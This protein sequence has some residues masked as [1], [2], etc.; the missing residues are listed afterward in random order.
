MNKK[1][2]VLATALALLLTAG[3]KSPA[4]IPTNPT[5]YS[6]PSVNTGTWTALQTAATEITGT[7]FT[8]NTV[9]QGN[10]CYAVTAIVNNQSPIL[11]S[12]PSNTFLANIAA[13]QTSEPLVW[14]AG[15]GGITPTGYIMYRIAAIQTSL[16]TPL[17][18]N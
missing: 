10:W 12:V 9:S 4:Q 16:A 7:S 14:T 3:C 2:I 6:C 13:G 11:K 1:V 15:T 18:L 8:D 5:A 17:S